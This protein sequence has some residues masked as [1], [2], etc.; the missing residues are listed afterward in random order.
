M[1]MP[2]SCCECP[3]CHP[4]GKDEPWNYA[5]F[6]TMADIN[7]DEWDKQRHPD[8]PIKCDIEDIN[9]EIED[10]L[11]ACIDIIDNVKKGVYP[12]IYS[13]A[14]MEGRKITYKHCL[15]IIDKH[16]NT[17]MEGDTD[18]DSN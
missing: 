1:D 3:I 8:C 16:I 4:K 6:Q 14:Q 7:I 17:T 12:Q 13:N 11:N 2:K 15:E 18:A 9:A 10:G 5:C